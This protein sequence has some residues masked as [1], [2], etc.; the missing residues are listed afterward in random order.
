VIAAGDF[1]GH[2][3]LGYS[4]FTNNVGISDFVARFRPDGVAEWAFRTGNAT[5]P[6]LNAVALDG[7]GAVLTAGSYDSRIVLGSTVLTNQ[8][9]DIYITRIISRPELRIRNTPSSWILSWPVSTPFPALAESVETSEDCSH[10]QPLS[11]PANSVVIEQANL[12]ADLKLL[13]A[14]DEVPGLFFRLRSK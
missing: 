9:T 8:D 13:R 10:W 6:N 12:V 5:S 14:S 7:T 2:L 4:A 1:G 3:K 11:A